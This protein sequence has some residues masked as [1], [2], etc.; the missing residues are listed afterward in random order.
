M[1]LHFDYLEPEQEVSLIPSEIPHS[2]AQA[3][4][5]LANNIRTGWLN[6]SFEQSYSPRTL[7]GW[8]TLAIRINSF[9][10]AFMLTYGNGL[11]VEE[12]NA[13]T[14]LWVSSGMRDASDEN[15]L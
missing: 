13:L 7:I 15:L 5:T 6:Q 11:S 2:I 4:V 3:M 12:Q 9:A 8:A 10:S 14:S 1:K